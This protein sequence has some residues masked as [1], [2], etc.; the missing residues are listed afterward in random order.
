MHN[1][2]KRILEIKDEEIANALAAHATF[3]HLIFRKARSGGPNEYVIEGPLSRKPDID[4]IVENT[5]DLD[6]L[7]AQAALED[8]NYV[9]SRLH[10]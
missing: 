4:T 5:T 1:T 3:S 9:G 7:A 2:Y 8:F 10:Y 6:T